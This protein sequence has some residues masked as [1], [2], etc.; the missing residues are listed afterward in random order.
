MRKPNF[1]KAVLILL[2]LCSGSMMTCVVVENLSPPKSFVPSD[3]AGTW[4]A[5]YDQYDIPDGLSM[6]RVHGVETITLRTDGTYQQVFSGVYTGPWNKW[7]LEDGWILHLRGARLFIMG[8]KAAEYFAQGEAEAHW[9]DCLGRE[10]EL[11]GTELILC[12]KPDPN[13]PGGIILEH[14]PVG[15]PDSPEIV[16]FH[17]IAA[18]VPTTTSVP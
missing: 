16:E 5:D 12:A 6:G 2:L 4:Q 8:I 14:L 10:I 11:D 1:L 18:P 3:L 17:R 15:D 7:W 9:E 13:A